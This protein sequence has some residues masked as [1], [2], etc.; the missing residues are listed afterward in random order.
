MQETP[1]FIGDPG[2]IRTSDLQLR[3]LLTTPASIRPE[4]RSFFPGNSACT[5]VNGAQDDNGD[6]Q[7]SPMPAGGVSR[8]GSPTSGLPA[9]MASSRTARP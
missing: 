7:T 1:D 6:N 8:S 9:A 2:W 3:R 5:L 4:R